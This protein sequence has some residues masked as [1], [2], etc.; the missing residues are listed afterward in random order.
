MIELLKCG[1]KINLIFFLLSFLIVSN[2]CLSNDNEKDILNDYDFIYLSHP[3]AV[4]SISWRQI[5][6][7][8]PK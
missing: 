6:R 1:M 2:L 5:S 7:F 8:M 3:R 4:T